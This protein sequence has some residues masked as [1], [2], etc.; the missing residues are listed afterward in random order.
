MSALGQVRAKEDAAFPPK[1]R[2][3][4]DILPASVLN[5]SVT[6]SEEKLRHVH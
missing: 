3:E 2:R 1:N 6:R 5:I 4:Y